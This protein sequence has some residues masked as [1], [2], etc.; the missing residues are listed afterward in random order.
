MRV[1]PPTLAGLVA[2]AVVSTQAA[3]KLS[4][5]HWLPFNSPLSFDLGN[6]ACGEGRRQALWRDWRGDWWW[7]A[8]VANP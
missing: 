7:G 2:L 1:I 4:Q 3:P 5:Q 8:C 6:Q